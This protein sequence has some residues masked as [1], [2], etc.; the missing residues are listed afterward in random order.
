MST[1]VSIIVPCYNQSSFL[2]KCL[3]TVLEQTFQDWECIIVND[4]SKDNTEAVAKIWVEKDS[5]FQYLYKE[6]GGLSSARN[7]GM[8]ISKGEYLFFLDSDDHLTNNQAIQTFIS[9]LKN[10]E[11]DV[12][13]GDLE[14]F[15][16]DGRKE[17]A[18][19]LNRYK[20]KSFVY[21]N[22][23]VFNAFLDNDISS[24]ACNK[25]FLSSFIKKNN[26]SF[27]D[28]LLHEDELWSFEVFSKARKAVTFNEITYSYFKG[29]E[30]SITANYTQKNI[31]SII[32]IIKT[33]INKIC[34][35]KVLFENIDK[36]KL[37]KHIVKLSRSFLNNNVIISQP[38]LWMAKYNEVSS[39]YKV[40]CLNNIEQK[41][42]YP[43]I[44]NHFLIKEKKKTYT[45][46]GSGVY[47]NFLNKFLT[48]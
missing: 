15:F 9:H 16:T 27:Q 8:K 11:M 32:Y 18:T 34:T 1:K 46:K 42:R 5:R 38:K 21:E 26:I 41:F 28:N 14:Y 17:R 39:I 24:P 20:D 12:V 10:E 7:A 43:S 35:E 36:N 22:N 3:Q 6:N 13:C 37:I 47:M 45:F 2:D 48:F 30:H 25:L 31:D 19:A 4:G 23:E 40:S 33:I 44:F 29:N